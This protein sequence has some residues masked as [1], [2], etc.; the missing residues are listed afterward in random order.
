MGG[1][2]V[3]AV[4]LAACSSSSNSSTTTTT[5]SS[6]SS[7]ASTS[8]SST[9]GVTVGAG[10][11]VVVGSIATLTG[12]IASNFNGTPAG[13]EA[14]F[15]MINAQGG[16]NGHKFLLSYNLDDGSNPATFSQ[17]SHTIIE[18]DHVFA[19]LASTFFFSPDF[20]VSNNTP[21]FGYNVS[22]N[23]AGSC[24]SYTGAAPSSCT[25]GPLNLF[26]AGGSTQNY[27]LG[28]PSVAWAIKET[29]SHSIAVISY[30]Q[31]ITS[32]YDACN[33][34]A[35]ELSNAGFSVTS[36]LDA[37]LGG[38][39]TSEVQ[40]MQ[41]NGVDFVV[42]CMQ[43]SDDITMS[44]EL[45]QY[46]LTH[47]HQLWFDGYDDSL[48]KQYN[49][50]MQGVYLN[51][52]DSVPFDAPTAYPGHYP[53]EAAYLAAMNKYEPQFV[54]SQEALQGWM[55]AVLLAQGVKLAGNNVSQA[56]V[57]NQ[58]NTITGF[59]AGGVS[60]VTNWT[61]AHDDRIITYPLCSAFVQAKGNTF[62]PALNQAPQVFDCFA[63][64]TLSNL[65]NPV[66]VAAQPGTP[67]T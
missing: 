49:S 14:Y 57:I 36:F 21:T 39:Y 8:S 22:G 12:A 67:G 28:A 17:L 1:A 34:D 38:S 60:S 62:V 41:A 59:T 32:S 44:R 31:A 35:T 23:W 4:S 63:K 42:S 43:A 48:L 33:A 37:Q 3:L 50:L 9:G 13:M 2:V 15:D 58:M 64:S 45:Q 16:V 65:K 5:S 53:G 10:Q 6:T 29:H 56:N 11:P 7:T 46:G 19:V 20:F 61:N 52:N 26:A 47:V 54:H 40:R 24:P 30:G 27:D 55:S 25:A 66:L 18:Q 51:I